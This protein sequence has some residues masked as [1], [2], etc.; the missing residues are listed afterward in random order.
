MARSKS[1]IAYV[2]R[3]QF[4]ISFLNSKK[5]KARIPLYKLVLDKKA[6]IG[7]SYFFWKRD[8]VFNNK[9][10]NKRFVLYNGYLFHVLKTDSNYLGLKL[11]EL[12]VTR[13]SVKHKGKQRQVKKREKNKTK[14]KVNKYAVFAKV[15]KKVSN[16]QKTRELK[17]KI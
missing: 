17:K 2:H 1:K 14:V 7:F 6:K 11:G 8:S 9:L 3:A 4:P 12:T 10:A 13:R 16:R 15:E 5:K